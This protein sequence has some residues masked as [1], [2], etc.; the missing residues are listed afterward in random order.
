MRRP[1]PPDSAGAT[2]TPPAA[3]PTCK[4][5]ELTT[6]SKTV[7][8]ATYWRCTT[9]GEVWN[10]ERLETGSRYWPRYR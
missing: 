4:S 8:A 9:C 1:M 3:C 7:T 10:P 5:K 2:V 6:V